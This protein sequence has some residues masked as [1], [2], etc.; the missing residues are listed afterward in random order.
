MLRQAGAF[1]NAENLGFLAKTS[2]AW[3]EVQTDVGIIQDYL[4][5]QLGPETT[6]HY[7]HRNCVSDVFQ[8]WKTGRDPRQEIVRAARMRRS[9]G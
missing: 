8:L 2:P 1:L 3:R 6:E 4:G 7:M 9:L 5:A